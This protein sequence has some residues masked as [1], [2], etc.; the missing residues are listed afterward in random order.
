MEV[1]VMSR[2]GGLG[3]AAVIS[4]SL[5]LGT[6]I[7]SASV[8]LCVPKREGAAVLTP[9]HGKCKR[10]FRLAGLGAEGKEGKEGRSGPEGKAGT[11][12]FSGSELETLKSLLPHLKF[13]DAGVGGKPTVQFSGLNVQVVNGE[14]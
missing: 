14:G 10:G 12:G 6:G 1:F 8:K 11:A 4:F 9:K 3:V 13:I 2:L 7:A 5:L